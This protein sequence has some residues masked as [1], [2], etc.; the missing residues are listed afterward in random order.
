MINEADAAINEMNGIDLNGKRLGVE[1]SRRNRPR[2]P[3]PGKYFGAIKRDRPPYPSSRYYHQSRHAPPH[4]NYNGSD[5]HRGYSGHGPSM[6][7][8]SYDHPPASYSRPPRFPDSRRYPQSP[9]YPPG[10]YDDRS[11]G[12]AHYRNEYNSFGAARS[13]EDRRRPDFDRRGPPT[14]APGIPPVNSLPLRGQPYPPRY[15]PYP[16][17]Q[18]PSP[19]SPPYVGGAVRR[20]GGA[21]QPP[22]YESGSRGPRSRSPPRI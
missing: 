22:F 8:H 9:S 21:P 4:Y 5:G 3:T 20:Y 11:R 12:P 7:S 2:S 15:D 6:N 19:R 18:D 10:A 14:V 17:H 16:P 13:F 1:H